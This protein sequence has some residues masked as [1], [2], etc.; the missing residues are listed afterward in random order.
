MAPPTSYTEDELKTYLHARA[1]TVASLFGWSTAGGSYNNVV[2]DTLRAMG[3][4]TITGVDAGALE[5]VGRVKLWEF[6]L[7]Q[8]TTYY[9]FRADNE[10]YN[11]SDMHKM[12]LAALEIAQSDPTYLSNIASVGTVSIGT[13]NHT[14]DPYANDRA[15]WFTDRYSDEI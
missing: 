4:T 10:Q 15:S 12:L 11:R 6:A 7:E 8:L 1:G 9:T 13:M 2:N 3:E 5:A 14:N